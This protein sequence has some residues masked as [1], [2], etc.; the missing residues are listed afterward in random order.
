[1]G[2]GS[3]AA[4]FGSERGAPPTETAD[5]MH[6]EVSAS[7]HP[8]SA[9]PELQRVLGPLELVMI[10][11]GSAIGAGIFV[12]TGT[13]AAEY[14]GSAVTRSYLIA[15]LACM[16]TTLCHAELAAMLPVA[17]VALRV[18]APDLPR[19]FRVPPFP[20]VPVPGTVGCLYLM[21]SLPRGARWRL[22]IGL[23]LGTIAYGFV[24]ARCCPPVQEPSRD[25]RPAE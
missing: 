22:A 19:P 18:R 17:V 14:A 9:A 3:A 4:R 1:M 5:P 12:M 11:V 8:R 10:G 15:G 24:R 16:L 25:A 21:Y 23:A 6:A 2:E 13:V 7:A 20:V